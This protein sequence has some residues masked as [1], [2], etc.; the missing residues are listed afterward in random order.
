MP[1]IEDYIDLQIKYEKKYGEKTMSHECGQFFEIYGV[2]NE[3]ETVGKIYEVA[4][5]TN[6]SI[7][8]RLDKFAPQVGKT[9]WLGFSN[10]SFEKW[11]DILLKHNYTIIKIEQDSH[12]IKDPN[13]KITEIISQGLI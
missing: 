5:I 7:A 10:R 1:L 11:K 9:R 12:G 13:R 8:E 2:V 3:T 4:D 6:L